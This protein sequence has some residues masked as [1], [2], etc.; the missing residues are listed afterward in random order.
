M[1]TV[2]GQFLVL[3]RAKAEIINKILILSHK[4]GGYHTCH[5][6]GPQENTLG[7]DQIG[8]LLVGGADV[9]RFQGVGARIQG[10][11]PSQ[12]CPM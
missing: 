9:T 8:G 1:S 2:L 3:P 5:C 11:E 12:P 10:P 6:G 7:E 4:V